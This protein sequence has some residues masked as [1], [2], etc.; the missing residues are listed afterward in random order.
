MRFLQ[1][2]TIN[3]MEY[4]EIYDS[5]I[6]IKLLRTIR[7]YKL[8][9]SKNFNLNKENCKEDPI[10]GIM[11]SFM[12][13]MFKLGEEILYDIHFDSR[14]I[15]DLIYHNFMFK[16]VND[17]SE[18][19][20]GFFYE[21]FTNLID[22][23]IEYSKKNFRKVQKLEKLSTYE[24]NRK[25]IDNKYVDVDKFFTKQAGLTNLKDIYENL[26]EA[27]HYRYCVYKLKK[28]EKEQENDF[29]DKN[30][31]NSSSDEEE[32]KTND[33]KCM[34]T[35][36][37]PLNK[38]MSFTS[39]KQ[40]PIIRQSFN[41]EENNISFYSENSDS[42]EKIKGLV[43]DF[44][45]YLSM[46]KTNEITFDTLR[47]ISV[48]IILA[49]LYNQIKKESECLKQCTLA[50]EKIKSMQDWVSTLGNLTK[51][52]F[53]SIC[54]L[55][56]EKIFFI[57]SNLSEKF[58]QKKTQFFIYL[59]LLD[60]GP[61]FDSRIRISVFQNIMDFMHK[62][63]KKQP[64]KKIR[65]ESD[66]QQSINSMIIRHK[67]RAM[68]NM[69]MKVSKYITYL[70]DVNCPFLLEKDFKYMFEKICLAYSN[71]TINFALFNEELILNKTDV[72]SDY[73]FLFSIDQNDYRNKTSNLDKAIFDTLN[74]FI[75]H[76]YPKNNNYL[77]VLTNIDANFDFSLSNL[78]K[79]SIKIFKEKYSLIILLFWDDK[80][81]DSPL[82]KKKLNKLR[83]WI[84]S[85]SNGI[86]IIIK[87]YSVIQY[88]MTC[89]H[90][91]KFKE[92]D[93]IVLKN[94]V[95]SIDLNLHLEEFFLKKNTKS[96]LKSNN[97]LR[98]S[99]QVL[100][101]KHIQINM[102]DESLTEEMI[103]FNN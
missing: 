12:F 29:E 83:M 56:Y 27:I 69:T 19:N 51:F 97:T 28:M 59:K 25:A 88:L 54:V 89:I 14:L 39:L 70:I 6:T 55:F 45:K 26:K 7:E 64:I 58:D 76:E 65:N 43:N 49:N 100:D 60:L 80:I 75:Y 3:L 86:M 5:L 33:F 102:E 42:Q 77:Y 4:H 99:T 46:I 32:D 20:V 50:M 78:S 52:S 18:K 15:S 103:Y 2:R 74:N 66:E 67:I 9:S 35:E 85:N 62:E 73:N 44:L 90:P 40:R 68:M 72:H 16:I 94:L 101:K 41:I 38:I 10:D 11:K 34:T 57:F 82:L 71:L 53:L 8:V 98:K 92:F 81:Y 30:V 24:K 84:E 37:E 87:N 22:K 13:L 36:R 95:T 61:I 47:Q 96:A 63:L 79:I 48:H 23:T 1:K 31:C 17:H 93:P 21:Y 91:I